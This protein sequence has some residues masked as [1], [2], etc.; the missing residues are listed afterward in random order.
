M[1]YTRALR[2]KENDNDFEEAAPRRARVSV[3]YN[4]EPRYCTVSRCFSIMLR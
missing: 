2:A 3:E 4:R 1:V